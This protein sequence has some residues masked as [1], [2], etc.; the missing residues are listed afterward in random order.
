LGQ[1]LPDIQKEAEKEKARESP[2]LPPEYFRVPD[3]KFSFPN[4]EYPCDLNL[5]SEILHS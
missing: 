4:Q 2:V 3:L 1:K 5:Y